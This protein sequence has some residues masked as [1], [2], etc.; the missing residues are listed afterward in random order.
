M[1][2]GQDEDKTITRKVYRFEQNGAPPHDVVM[3]CM[4]YMLT[5]RGGRP[6]TN[7]P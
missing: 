2:C 1:V 7:R 4:E 6:C 3:Q 5:T